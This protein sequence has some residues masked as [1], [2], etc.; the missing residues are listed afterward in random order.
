MK[1]CLYYCEKSSLNDATNCYVGI[2][3]KALAD[4]NLTL[5]KTQDLSELADADIVMTITVKPSS[6]LSARIEKQRPFSG[7]KV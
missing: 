2:I 4:K 7:R 1:A 5:V 3:E 6:R